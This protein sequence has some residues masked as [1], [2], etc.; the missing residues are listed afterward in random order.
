MRVPEIVEKM[1]GENHSFFGMHHTEETRRKISETKKGVSYGTNPAVSKSNRRRTSENHPLYGKSPSEETLKKQSE[2]KLGEKNAKWNTSKLEEYGGLD[3]LY[4]VVEIGKTLDDVS[5]EIGI[6]VGAIV[7]YLNNRGE[8]WITLRKNANRKQKYG[9]IDEYG[10]LDFIIDCIKNGK[11][12]D[13]VAADLGWDI[14]LFG[15]I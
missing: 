9:I 2:S 3:Y 13:E 4:G 11:T 8:S 5:K 1:S 10:G 7:S 6:S 15:N 14:L 12:A